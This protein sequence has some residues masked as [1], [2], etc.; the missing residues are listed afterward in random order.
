M[1]SI[2]GI[3]TQI[4]SSK[5]EVPPP[6][7]GPSVTLA[8][9]QLFVFGGRLVSTRKMTNQLFV[10]DVNTHVWTRHIPSPDSDKPPTPRYFHSANVYKRSLII[11]GG[12]GYT[13]KATSSSAAT[14]AAIT[15]GSTIGDDETG[16]N[17]NSSGGLCVVD[18]LSI[19]DLDTM[20]WRRPT[21]HPSLFSPRPRYAHL[22]EI[23]DDKLVVVGGQDMNNSYLPELNILDLKSWE[24]VQVKTIDKHVGAYR[25]IAVTTPPGTRLPA[26]VK[27]TMTD[28]NTTSNHFHHLKQQS[29]DDSANKRQQRRTSAVRNQS[30]SIEEPSPIYLYTNYNFTDVKRELQLVFMPSSN[31]N[32]PTIEDCSSFMTGSAMPPGLRFP[33]GHTLGH[34]LIL[35]GTYLSPQ[36]Q[37]YSVW[38]L[39][40]G[41]LTWSRIETGTIFSQGSWNRGVLHEAS[42]RFIVF[43][44]QQRSLLDDYHHRQTNF[45]HMALVDLEAFG[46]YQLPRITCSTLAQEMGL[47][48][49]NEP[50]VSDFYIVTRENQSIPVNS[51]VLA[52]RW[53]YF[54]DLMETNKS[55][56]SSSTGHL[57]NNNMDNSDNNNGAI[58]KSHSM[59]FPYSYP[60]VIA[61]LQFI[62]TDNLLTAQQY[63]PH[64]L[65]QL[66]LLSDMYDLPRL[67]VLTTHALHQMLN[68]STAPL[69]FETAALSHQTSLQ[70]RALK[71][72]IA[73]KKMIQQQ[74]MVQAG[75]QMENSNSTNGPSTTTTTTTMTTP[76]STSTSAPTMGTDI[77][78]GAMSPS[79]DFSPSSFG[80]IQRQQQQ[81]DLLASRRSPPVQQQHSPLMSPQASR[82]DRYSSATHDT[83]YSHHP[84]S[85][86]MNNNRSPSTSTGTSTHT[87]V[88]PSGSSSPKH[89]LSSSNTN[90]LSPPM[91]AN[92]FI[93]GPSGVGAGSRMLGMSPP[94]TPRQYNSDLDSSQE[95]TKSKKEKK[96]G[97]G[98][99]F[100]GG[101]IF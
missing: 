3:I 70:I 49:L 93:N 81:R 35:A 10:M 33:T 11:F 46:V 22:A 55:S 85:P 51:A 47:S 64:I 67:R 101:K 52:Q 86:L 91:S 61:L 13:R 88:A 78:T 97:P 26:A 4:R 94:S 83:P 18:D 95:K 8:G 45:D 28:D 54:A 25:S 39:N 62:Y 77:G 60:V 96:K 30:V 74:Q 38:S 82:Y 36:A 14:A 89:R 57:D 7:V 66:L 92:S 2:S 65:A 56:L 9:D 20:T 53:P 48:L 37:S 98:M 40:L 15:T 17:M 19:L 71:M 5:G 73:A 31:T 76:M 1:Q 69:I 16:N 27:E 21:I 41:T 42:N 79:A 24:W 84:H 87:A 23:V 100:F 29:E 99:N 34:H 68:M 50:A 6:L 72:M 90:P 75:I 58:L 63:Q 43:G 32:T 12:M 80:N 59:L 44:N